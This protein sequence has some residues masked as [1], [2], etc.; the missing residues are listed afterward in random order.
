[1]PDRNPPTGSCPQPPPSR[2]FP[3]RGLAPPRAG[4]EGSSAAG[5]HGHPSRWGARRA[6]RRPV[7]PSPGQHP[8]RPVR[9]AASPIPTGAPARISTPSRRAGRP[10]PAADQPRLSRDH[11]R[12][13][14][15][16][17]V[18]GLVLVIALGERCGVENQAPT[19]A[20]GVTAPPRHQYRPRRTRPGRSA[21]IPCPAS[22]QPSDRASSTDRPLRPERP[23]LPRQAR[24]RVSLV[25]GHSRRPST[26][27]P[28]ADLP[29]GRRHLW[30]RPARRP[31][32]RRLPPPPN[33]ARPHVTP[34]VT[35]PFTAADS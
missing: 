23:V 6:L 25:D 11:H 19:P 16:P 10:A 12:S 18:P 15:R 31:W 7:Q 17:A 13:I 27:A 26:R 21:E 24:N 28:R 9:A 14:S 1:V 30:R 29:T 8:G 35:S 20:F 33:T 5:D 22:Y 3:A 2:K 32:N 34:S 4:S